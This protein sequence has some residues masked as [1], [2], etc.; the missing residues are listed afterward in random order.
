[1]QSEFPTLTDRQI[2]A[3]ST[4][5]TD[6]VAFTRHILRKDTW[7]TQEAILRSVANHPRTAVKA[8]HSSGKT[9]IAA[10]AALWWITAHRDG[11]V[12]STAPTFNQV[13]LMLWGEIR[14]TAADLKEFY[15]GLQPN[16]TSFHL[17]PTRYAIGLSTNEGVNFQGFHGKVL[18]IMDEAPGIEGDIWE[19]IE[20]IRAGGDV[21]VLALGNPVIASGPFY[22]AFGSNR[23]GWNTITISA[24]DTPNLAGV[25]LEELLAMPD[26]ALKQNPR[27]Y[28]TTR[29]WVR[30]K[31]HEWGPDNPI[32]DSRVMG[33]F[34][35]QSEYSL[36]SLAWVEAAARRDG[37]KD[38]VLTAGIDVAGPGEDET[39]LAVR[40]GNALVHLQSWSKPDPRGEVLA[41]LRP[42]AGKLKCVNGDT[43]GIGYY[44]LKHLEDN[45]LP[46][47]HINVGSASRDPK[48]YL[49]LKAEIYWELRLRFQNGD[50]AGVKDER[51]MGQLAG[52]R[53]DTD[54]HGKIFI[55][56]KEDARKRGVKSPDRAEAIMLCYHQSKAFQKVTIA[57]DEKVSLWGPMSGGGGVRW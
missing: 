16:M 18:I 9:F 29:G 21:R 26:D 39:V 2:N 54:S 52:I 10:A 46:V 5:K 8:C 35:A 42:F 32:W 17:S 41:A 33:N 30:E 22:D 57:S 36:I 40:D 47:K 15:G 45:G 20:G 7:A 13:R 50:I 37:V 6:P 11:I 4:C 49:N 31:Y 53:W 3:L 25:S 38:G 34:P 43:A 24:L 55:E 12:V 51:T 19:A 56:P 27:P 14:R 23:A 1:M 28:L 44:F 48:K